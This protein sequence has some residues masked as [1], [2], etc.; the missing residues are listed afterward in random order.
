MINLKSF[1]LFRVIEL[2]I[3]LHTTNTSNPTNDFKTEKRKVYINRDMVIYLNKIE[4]TILESL[5]WRSD[6]PIW[7][8]LSKLKLNSEYLEKV[9]SPQDLEFSSHLFLPFP[10]NEDVAFQSNPNPQYIL[11]GAQTSLTPNTSS[12]GIHGTVVGIQSSEL[13]LNITPNPVTSS[14]SISSPMKHPTITRV[15]CNNYLDGTNTLQNSNKQYQI[16]SLSNSNSKPRLINQTKYLNYLFRK[17]YSL[18]YFKMRFI[19]EKLD[20]INI[21]MQMNQPVMLATMT[22]SSGIAS[23]TPITGFTSTPISNQ[24]IITPVTSQTTSITPQTNLVFEHQQIIY[25][26]IWNIFEYSLSIGGC[27]ESNLIR[28]RHLD[29]LLMCAIYLTCKISSINNIKFTDI[30]KVYRLID[31]HK[32]S[33]YRDV[34]IENSIRGDLIQFYN[35]IYLN[36]VRRYAT[37]ISQNSS[38]FQAVPTLIGCPS[39]VP[40]FQTS[41]QTTTSVNSNTNSVQVQHTQFCSRKIENFNIFVSPNKINSFLNRSLYYLGSTTTNNLPNRNKMYLY[42]DNHN[43]QDLNHTKSIKLINEMIKRNEIK[44]KSSNKRLFSDISSHNIIPTTNTLKVTSIASTNNQVEDETDGLK[45]KITKISSN[46]CTP[47]VSSTNSPMPIANINTQNR[48][49]SKIVS[50]KLGSSSNT[51]TTTTNNGLNNN[52]SNLIVLKNP[53]ITAPSSLSVLVGSNFSR[54]LQ[55]IHLERNSASNIK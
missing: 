35:R 14:S 16:L 51:I 47:I 23:S 18:S 49:L 26:K 17:F 6:S 5:V 24:P 21:V 54:K 42:V 4:E 37:Q 55:N 19:V 39:Q 20:L 36:R 7:T 43:N 13:V 1:D 52:N 38:K 11:N 15:V 22:S 2:F 50:T 30:M 25:K 48:F 28:D 27:T 29:Q 45:K 32:S 8:H 33:V 10:L 46:I 31:A 3:K 53:Q 40:K 9:A 34:L 12:T 44:I 41:N